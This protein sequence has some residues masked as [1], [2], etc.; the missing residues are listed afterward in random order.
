MVT[1]GSCARHR[2][3]FTLSRWLVLGIEDMIVWLARLARL[4]LL[5]SPCALRPRYPGASRR[6]AMCL[7]YLVL[8]A[9]VAGAPGA[10]RDTA[11]VVVSGFLY[12]VSAL[13]APAL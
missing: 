3:G 6:L 9:L 5:C 13:A 4:C 10:F 7:F 1:V 8:L 2:E 12:L 11:V